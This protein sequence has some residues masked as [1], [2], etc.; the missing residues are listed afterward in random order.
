MVIFFKGRPLPSITTRVTP[1]AT[2]RLKLI[3]AGV[4]MDQIA[5]IEYAT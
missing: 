3:T 4:K 1:A 2:A 5:Y